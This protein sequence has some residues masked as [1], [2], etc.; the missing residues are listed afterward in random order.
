MTGKSIVAWA[1]CRQARGQIKLFTGWADGIVTASLESAIHDAVVWK[2]DLRTMMN[3]TSSDVSNAV[4]MA[5]NSGTSSGEHIP[6]PW[7]HG[8]LSVTYQWQ[9]MVSVSGFTN[10]YGISISCLPDP[11]SPPTPAPDPT[12]PMSSI[13]LQTAAYNPPDLYQV[14]DMGWPRFDIT[15]TMWLGKR[16]KPV[17][18][19]AVPWTIAQDMNCFPSQWETQSWN[20]NI[21]IAKHLLP[22]SGLSIW[23]YWNSLTAPRLKVKLIT[24]P[25]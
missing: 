2:E 16:D 4:M 6:K 1:Q 5:T 22:P 14:D 17:T 11:A 8:E 7:L 25:T 20:V 9:R 19:M 3:N 12:A 10:I 18:P 21:P 13:V 24:A 15:Q 23:G